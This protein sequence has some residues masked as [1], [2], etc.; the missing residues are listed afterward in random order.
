MAFEPG[1]R[2]LILVVHGDFGCRQSTMS[3]RS[4]LSVALLGTLVHSVVIT[5]LNDLSFANGNRERI[6]DEVRTICRRSDS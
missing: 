6:I 5:D 3:L 1:V 4:T 2:A